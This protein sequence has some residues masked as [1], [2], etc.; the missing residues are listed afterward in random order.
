M[1]SQYILVNFFRVPWKI[2]W[3]AYLFH[4]VD[5]SHSRCDFIMFK[6]IISVRQF[7]HRFIFIIVYIIITTYWWVHTLETKASMLIVVGR[8]FSFHIDIISTDFFLGGGG[9]GGQKIGKWSNRSILFQD[10]W[11][12]EQGFAWTN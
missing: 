11:E 12:K 9:G 6:F 1:K 4:S 8:T 2:W 5:V 10:I 3:R 7:S